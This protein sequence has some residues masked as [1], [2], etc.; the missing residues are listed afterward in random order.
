RREVAAANPAFRVSNIRTQQ[1]INDAQTVRERL[2]SMLGLFFAAVALIL[3]G[4]GLYG[5]LH[6]SVLQRSREFGIRIAIGA[7]AA[8]IARIV[9]AEISL[10]VGIGVAAGLAL[11][12]VTARYTAALFYQAKP[13]DATILVAP[14][15]ALFAAALLAAAQPTLRAISTDPAQTL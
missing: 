6:Y 7:Q 15:V 3:A 13:S 8:A 10:T 5:V 2:L 9:I 11:G 1:E 14:L 4:V 12:F